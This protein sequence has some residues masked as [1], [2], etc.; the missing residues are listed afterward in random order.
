MRFA[1]QDAGRLSVAIYTTVSV[2][3]A[4]VFFALTVLTGDYTWVARL[5]GSAWVFLLSMIILMPTVT[6][7]VRKRLEG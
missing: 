5:G 2:L 4:G 6:P 1:A 7:W 3:A